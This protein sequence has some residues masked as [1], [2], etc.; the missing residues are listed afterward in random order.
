VAGVA[1]KEKPRLAK[2]RAKLWT[3]VIF[4][5]DLKQQ[6]PRGALNCS[7]VWAEKN[8]KA[9]PDSYGLS[10]PY[11]RGTF[12]RMSRRVIFVY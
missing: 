1:A 2:D 8:E 12:N 6:K 4:G 10:H 3:E 7:G 11:S 5:K 9:I